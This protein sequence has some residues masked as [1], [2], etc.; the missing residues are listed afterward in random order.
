MTKKLM[1][2]VVAVAA[3]FCAWAET[4]TVGNYTWTYRIGGDNTVSIYNGYSAAISPTPTG[5]VTIPSTLGGKPVTSIGPYAFDYCS[6]LTSVTIPDSV[7]SIGDSA[8][9]DCSSLTSVT[10]PNSVTSIGRS[11]FSGCSG[12]TSVTI[13]DSMTSIGNYAFEG[14]SSLT[15][16]TIP[17]N[18]ASIG[19]CAFLG[20]SGL[21][22]IQVGAGNA[23]YAS[24]NGLLLTKNETIL[25]QGVNGNVTIPDS[26]TSI[27]EY[28]FSDCSGLTSVT[29]GKGVTSIGNYA[30]EGC[31]SLTSVTIPDSV[32]SIGD[33]AFYGC[34]G[35]TS[36]TIP[37][38]VINIGSYAFYGCNGLTS[39]T[40][41][42]SVTNIGSSAFSGCSGLASV[43]IPDSVT[44]IGD[45]AFYGCG[46]LTSVT[47]PNGVTSIERSAFLDCKS[48]KSVTLP[49]NLTY[50]GMYA[51]SNCGLTNI[52]I[53][54][55]VKSVDVCAFARCAA[56]SAATIPDSVTSIGGGVFAGC[57]GLKTVNIGRGVR[58]L[59]RYRWVVQA[60]IV[61]E[62][63]GMFEG[64]SSL[65]NLTIPDSVR[66]ID[67]RAFWGCECLESI[68]I[69][70]SV[71]YI[72]SDAFHGCSNLVS[73]T[74]PNGVTNI[75]AKTFLGCAALS[76]VTMPTNVV[77]VESRAFDGCANIRTIALQSGV[78]RGYENLFG[79]AKLECV[80]CPVEFIE[81]WTRVFERNNYAVGKIYPLEVFYYGFPESIPNSSLDEEFHGSLERDAPI[82]KKY[83]TPEDMGYV[84][85][86]ET[87]GAIVSSGIGR[88]PRIGESALPV[89]GDGVAHVSIPAGTTVY[90]TLSSPRTTTVVIRPRKAG[91]TVQN[92]SPSVLPLSG[93]VTLTV[94][95]LLLPNDANVRLV[96]GD[97]G[98]ESESVKVLSTERLLVKFDCSKLT[99]GTTYS[100]VVDS[101]ED[102]ETAILEDSV[103]VARET[104]APLLTASLDVPSS[105]RAGRS[106]VFYI[107]YSNDGNADMPAPIFT[108]NA[109]NVI[110]STDGGIYTNS[111]KLLGLGSVGSAGT[112][113]P[114]ESFRL[115]V[116]AQVEQSASDDIS[117]ALSSSWIGATGS[118]NKLS[119]A[120]LFSDDYVYWHESSEHEEYAAVSALIGATW[121]D[122]YQNLSDYINKQDG[123]GFATADYEQ[124]SQGFAWHCMTAVREY[125]NDISPRMHAEIRNNTLATKETSRVVTD[126]RGEML[127]S[128]GDLALIEDP[129]SEL[130]NIPGDS[131][132]LRLRTERHHKILLT[133]N[134]L[135]GDVWIWGGNAWFRLFKPDNGHGHISSLFDPS[136]PSVLICHGNL[137]S[138][139]TDW[140]R[141]MAIAWSDA[142]DCN[143]LAVDWGDDS[144]ATASTDELWNGFGTW[145]GSIVNMILNRREMGW[146]EKAFCT[147]LD[148]PGVAARA[149]GLLVT[150]GIRGGALT[151]VGHSHGGHVGG[152]ICGLYEQMNDKV[153]RLVLLEASSLVSHS[154]LPASKHY[155][156]SWNR[157]SAKTTEFYKT[158]Y[159]MSMGS[160]GSFC[161]DGADEIPGIYNFMV[162]PQSES[163]YADTPAF[164]EHEWAAQVG[165]RN[166]SADKSVF[167]LHLFNGYLSNLDSDNAEG[168]M[169]AWRH[170]NVEEWFIETISRDNSGKWKNLGYNW[171]PSESCQFFGLPENLPEKFP[172]MF[173]G[174]IN[175][176]KDH[177]GLELS[178]P[179]GWIGEWRYEEQ[180]L[181]YRRDTNYTRPMVDVLQ[182]NIT[183]A[184]E[185]R[186][187]NVDIPSSIDEHDNKI[188]FVV[189]N[190]AN[191]LSVNFEDVNKKW[192]S[193][194]NE[195]WGPWQKKIGI[196]VWLCRPYVVNDFG[197]SEIKDED[198]NIVAL[199]D[200]DRKWS[201][202]A[203]K[204]MRIKNWKIDSLERFT[205]PQED[206]VKQFLLDIPDE[207]CHESQIHKIKQ[208]GESFLLVVGVGVSSEGG[209]EES[210]IDYFGDL[211]QTNNFYIQKVKVKPTG[212]TPSI[213]INDNE[214][215]DG[216]TA[217]ILVEEGQETVL[218]SV[219]VGNLAAGTGYRSFRW[220]ATGGAFD[221]NSSS[222]A[223]WT[224]P[225]HS[226]QD[227]TESTIVLAASKDQNGGTGT[228]PSSVSVKVRF[229]RKRV[230][231]ND[232]HDTRRSIIPRS[233]DPNEVVGP[234][235]S[236]VERYVKAGD[237]LSYT[238][239]FENKADASAAA[240]FVTIDNP[241]S[242]YLDWSTFELGDVGFGTQLDTGLTGKNTGIS[243]T[244][245]QGTN[246]VVRS[247]A[248]MD[249]ESGVASWFL[250]IVTPY[251]DSDGWPYADDPTGFLPPNNQETHCGEGHVSYRI[252]VRDDAPPYCVITN[253]ATIVFDYNE[254]IETE[255]SW[256][257][258]V[259][260][261]TT[262]AIT[263]A[264]VRTNMTLI[265]GCP[266]GEL[267]VPAARDGYTFVGWYTGP[268][269]SG[270]KIT[271]QSIV[272]SGDSVL[273]EHWINDSTRMHTIRFDPVRG[274]IESGQYVIQ[275]EHGYPIGELPVPIRDGFELMCW[276]DLDAPPGESIT[277]ETIITKDM[278]IYALWLKVPEDET[279]PKLFSDNAMDSI[280][281]A[282]FS[283]ATI[284]NGYL[285]S[286]TSGAVAG[287]IQVK[288]G[289][290]NAKTGLA[291][292]K[293]T[294]VGLDGKKKSLK[295]AEKGKAVIASNGPTAIALIGGEA[296]EIVIG[297][298]GLSGVYGAYTIDGARN[299]FSSKDKAEQNAA[300]AILSK[301]LGVINAAWREEGAVRSA[302]APYQM[303]SVTIGK[304]GKAKASVTLANGTKAMVNTQLLVGEEWLCVPVVVTKKMNLAFTLWL[305]V[306]GGAAVVEGLG[307]EVV[308]GKAGALKAGAKFRID[309]EAF[310]EKWG[311]SALPYLPDGVAVTQSGTRWTL[312]K[313]GKVQMAKDGTV[314]AAKLGDNP[315]AL[316]LSYKAKDG[317]FK[318]SFKAYSLVNG[319]PKAVTVRVAGVVIEGVGY[320]SAAIGKAGQVAVEIR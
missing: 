149:H 26:V 11:A 77:K 241:V 4:E 237:W 304:K 92:V 117:Y 53:P 191:N 51:F 41:P 89:D 161:S 281:F 143:V 206:T 111:V 98:I 200:A 225:L 175:R 269:G 122:F 224:V 286:T 217:N 67:E 192:L 183:Q 298:D 27:G 113:K 221:D 229:V 39:V 43:T 45:Y 57:S 52:T 251:G 302:I 198:L 109:D 243:E 276:I 107:N 205:K 133:D 234:L 166:P 266:Y 16:V 165:G 188:T 44:S 38:S 155:P 275:V 300:N 167:G 306:G 130:W 13:P 7:T 139:H 6:G 110:F 187:S 148:I 160:F 313:A 177:E 293:A 86:I 189:T 58:A 290:A 142:E 50:I 126:D 141:R 256:W 136:R 319:K 309:A 121:S 35:L 60:G 21:M 115:P 218:N 181:S 112:I 172:L 55:S 34:G 71:T 284:Y 124:M 219:G 158:S 317:S 156:S 215:K 108:I 114:G 81:E 10:I 128:D 25:I 245:I 271:S 184:I 30:F 64:C 307:G 299:F 244:T 125:N 301:W 274:V 311:Q 186:I 255:P 123:Y 214:Y 33:H 235:G 264:G 257:N 195:A 22:S 72:G 87:N 296:C 46:G 278:T 270:R 37:N 146:P 236:G 134:S 194:R 5:A 79:G 135:P 272:Q 179:R 250:R 320:G 180:I 56:L 91:V 282:P 99:V 310:S 210:P 12:L 209:D 70:E 249:V 19:G 308:A 145:L 199:R 171:K 138:I 120:S 140:V 59:G 260:Q 54:N 17:D 280:A 76:H 163:R 289:K 101:K 48:L 40:I 29:I 238:I 2:M 267:P 103:T 193:S 176:R 104:G 147:A 261:T 277:P 246:L 170:D 96:D 78:F 118:S 303:L 159:W 207:F 95:G 94:D 288:V 173:H 230:E 174:V 106:F 292:V 263:I 268:N 254:P 305:P 3:A 105:L 216:D 63:S 297:K 295:A 222:V 312:P 196:G 232:A 131:S 233:C 154:L 66:R 287:T 62:D 90:I 18:V 226:N 69:P 227:A 182:D 100:L 316:K 315:A 223:K 314:D 65:T 75:M 162:I 1:T 291:A 116:K 318:G 185:Y 279:R 42:N 228:L 204:W 24:V 168:R 213:L 208:E 68:S 152:N 84:L 157:H 127:R 47:I 102:A 283:S 169:E 144:T 31:S 32:T 239:F 93:Y 82:A 252:R 36:V 9:S 80:Y 248:S 151:V 201:G 197:V 273:Y 119:L 20:C 212:S 240:Q 294:V 28:A 190:A 132:Q 242:H 74:I 211:C 203:M 23:N 85:E 150:A 253:S 153:K 8:F 202:G 164:F 88:L 262:V 137:H 178:R 73:V 61:L 258:V 129:N 83:T 14:C 15:S 97:Q 265:V 49:D 231:P 285:Y 247:E 259:A 220:S